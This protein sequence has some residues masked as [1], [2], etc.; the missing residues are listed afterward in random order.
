MLSQWSSVFNFLANIAGIT[1][2][3]ALF[4]PRLTDLLISRFSEKYKASLAKDLEKF[5]TSIH[6]DTERSL[7]LFKEGLRET[8]NRQERLRIRLEEILDSINSS[9]MSLSSASDTNHCLRIARILVDDVN[10]YEQILRETGFYRYI[11]SID[12]LTEEDP[13]LHQ[14]EGAEWISELKEI[15]YRFSKD[16][17]TFCANLGNYG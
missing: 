12:R 17:S 4:V 5:K 9:R 16:I 6:L 8:A 13:R 2:F 15:L 3:L 11:E 14:N 1:A 10:K 7:H